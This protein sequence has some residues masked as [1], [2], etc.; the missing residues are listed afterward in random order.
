MI[1]EKIKQILESFQ[2]KDIEKCKTDLIFLALHYNKEISEGKPYNHSLKHILFKV[3][4]IRN[5]IGMKYTCEDFEN[6]NSILEETLTLLRAINDPKI[7]L[8]G[9]FREN[10]AIDDRIIADLVDLW[11]YTNCLYHMNLLNSKRMDECKVG[12][13]PFIDQ[14]MNIMVYIQDQSRL[15]R[16]D[17]A[18]S[19]H[20]DFFT[21]MESSVADRPIEYYD[22]LKN[23]LSDNFESTLE[24]INEIVHYLYYQYGKTLKRKVISSEII[25]ARIGP[26]EN[27]EFVK[28]LHIANQRHLLCAVEEG[29]RYGYYKL[30]KKGKSKEGI[31][32]CLFSAED[33][34]KL[35]ARRLGVHRRTYQFQSHMFFNIRCNSN[36]SA[37]NELLP[38][39]A[40][41][42]IDS[43]SETD[44]LLD[45]SRF[46]PD[47]ILIQ[48]AEDL[49]TP[50]VRAEEILTKDYYLDSI[51][52]DVKMRDF[53]CT[54]K[55]LYTL[56]EILY[57]ASLR[58]IDD[59]KQ[60]TY[61][62]EVCL[63]DISYLSSE[64]SRIHNFDAGYAEKLLDRFIFHEKE[65]QDDDVFAQPLLKISKTQ[66]ILS[67]VLLGQMNL[68]R[69]IE[70]QFIR[71]NKSVEEVGHIFEKEF[72][73]SLSNGYSTGLSNAKCHK[74]PHFT[75]NTNK[76]AYRA[77]DGKDIEFDVI[78]VLGDYLILTELKSI[79]SSYDLADVE[80]RREHVKTAVEQLHRRA[81][82]VR[83]DWEKIKK[84]VSID[85]PDQPFD[86]DHIILVVCTDSYDYTPLKDGDVFITD[87]STYLKYFTRPC[88]S[89]IEDTKQGMTI[90]EK[91]NLW[92]KGYPDAEEFQD[93]LLAPVTTNLFSRCLVKRPTPIPI[94]DEKDIFIMFEDYILVRDPI[95]EVALDSNKC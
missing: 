43:Q 60:D 51:V 18:E 8:Q 48:K 3:N 2:N 5:P 24:C 88:V 54:Y 49:A 36:V 4:L 71:F 16:Q 14:L 20:K 25:S 39:L 74:I 61:V 15:L 92:K 86:Q 23:S 80:Q 29:I 63:A 68:D 58:L 34:K 79:M 33:D 9:V 72:I 75:V 28:Y 7:N 27:V 42:L 12:R 95:R 38:Q 45:L 87:D 31:P 19:R 56:T 47:K 26:Y 21:G 81:E 59:R 89:I 41:M 40:K 82:S 35:K 90:K 6:T 66:V 37:A 46:H 83:N 10:L 52:K 94:M 69:A 32:V 85:L 73:N 70:R 57:A 53:L 78:S 50:Q 93:Y 62:K 64:L 76:V 55:Y 77:F 91:M 44:I 11:A 30:E 1:S 22:N 84:M 67:P 65:N 13:L 17:I